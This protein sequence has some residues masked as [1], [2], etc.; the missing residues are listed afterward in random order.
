[1][2]K[3][4][5]RGLFLAIVGM[6]AVGCKK[7]LKQTNVET[8]KKTFSESPLKSGYNFHYVGPVHNIVL[9]NLMNHSGWENMTSSEQSKYADSITKV[10][11]LSLNKDTTSMPNG[12]S[13]TYYNHA[14]SYEGQ[15]VLY[16]SK[17]EDFL[18]DSLDFSSLTIDYYGELLSF[19]LKS[20]HEGSESEDTKSEILSFAMDIETE[21]SISDIE[22][23]FLR[24]ASSV[25]Y[26]SISYWVDYDE[27]NPAGLSGWWKKALADVGG[28]TSGFVGSLVY[29]NNSSGNVNPFSAGG[30]VGGLASKLAG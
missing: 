13:L 18:T 17:V 8:E 7:E 16:A 9:D 12:F 1:M 4:I 28:F 23:E 21:E 3:L 11:L 19:I 27:D 10:E 6:F 30:T 2:K 22:K 25:A 15:E 26:Y 29:N 24:G 14:L 5:Y 20:N